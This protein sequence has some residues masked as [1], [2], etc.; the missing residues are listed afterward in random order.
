MGQPCVLGNV[1]V[2][3]TS[4]ELN[5]NDSVRFRKAGLKVGGDG[6]D[7]ELR[8][9][10]HERIE[11]TARPVFD[12]PLHLHDSRLVRVV[13]SNPA[14]RRVR[15]I[16]RKSGIENSILHLALVPVKTNDSFL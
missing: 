2:R 11:A 16:Q 10:F 7:K 8:Q 15:W 9:A 4:S 12:L 1:N 6:V 13:K 5:G 3:P 14:I